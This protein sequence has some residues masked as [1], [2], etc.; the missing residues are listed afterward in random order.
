ME[1]L[2]S[3][4]AHSVLLR[5]LISR[6]D[7]QF[8]ILEELRDQPYTSTLGGTSSSTVSNSPSST[9]PTRPSSTGATAGMVRDRKDQVLALFEDPNTPTVADQEGPYKEAHENRTHADVISGNAELLSSME[10]MA[11]RINVLRVR[12]RGYE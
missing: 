8:R 9:V 2:Q 10:E 7:E 12:L 6:Q 11:N 1:I 4:H 3:S 5:D